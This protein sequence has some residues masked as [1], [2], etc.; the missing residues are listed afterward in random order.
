MNCGPS[1]GRFFGFSAEENIETHGRI[2]LSTKLSNAALIPFSSIKVSF[3][4]NSFQRS[5]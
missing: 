3:P 4:A 1:K 2:Y 5:F